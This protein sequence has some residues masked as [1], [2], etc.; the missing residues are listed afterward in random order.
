MGNSR[1]LLGFSQLPDKPYFLFD[2]IKPSLAAGL[3]PSQK[4]FYVSLNIKF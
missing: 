3:K 1:W 2:G 4:S